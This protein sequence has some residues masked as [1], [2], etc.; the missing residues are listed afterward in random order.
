MSQPAFAFSAS[1]AP[2][3]PEPDGLS[4]EQLAELDAFFGAAAYGDGL[5][6][7]EIDQRTQWAVLS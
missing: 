7:L 3:M 4:D 5:S 2:E 1:P 6:C